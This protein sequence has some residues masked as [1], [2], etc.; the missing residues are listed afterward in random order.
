MMTELS[1]II[2]Q[3]EPVNPNWLDQA[4]E[5]LDSLTKPRGS[6]GRLEELATLYVGMRVEIKATSTRSPLPPKTAREGVPRGTRMTPGD[7]PPAGEPAF[8]AL[9][10]GVE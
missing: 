7:P 4:R 3:I 10:V 8:Q 9:L 2:S 6:L 5:R 1:Q